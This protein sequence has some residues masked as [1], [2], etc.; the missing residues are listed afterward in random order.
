MRLI[1]E[2]S[3]LQHALCKAERFGW[4]STPPR[5]P[6]RT[7]KQY[8]KAE[9]EDVLRTMQTVVEAYDLG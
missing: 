3:E 6:E 1:E 9:M 5:F 2:L 4:E 7:N 8:V